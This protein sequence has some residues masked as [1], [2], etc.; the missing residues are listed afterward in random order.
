MKNLKEKD[1]NVN[2]CAVGW[3]HH[4]AHTA[5][6]PL[7]MSIFLPGTELDRCD[8]DMSEIDLGTAVDALRSRPLDGGVFDR[9]DMPR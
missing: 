3:R 5:V 9:D 2:K 6:S 8:R 7:V 4:A 1:P